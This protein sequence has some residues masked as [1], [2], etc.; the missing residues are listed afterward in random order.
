MKTLV[1]SILTLLLITPAVGANDQSLCIAHRGY[2]A[3]FFENSMEAIEQAVLFGADGVEFDIH[4]TKDGVPILSHDP[5]LEKVVLHNPKCPFERDISKLYFSEIESC[6]LRNGEKIPTLEEVL[7]YLA[8]EDVM[9]FVDL[10]DSPNGHFFEL[11]ERYHNLSH[12]RFIAF[13]QNY[14]RL[15]Q[16]RLPTAKTLLLSHIIPRGRQFDGAN[17]NYRSRHYLNGFRRRGQE[18]GVWT[19]NSH[20]R[21]R[22]VLNMEIDFITTD[23]VSRCLALRD[24][25]SETLDF[26]H[27]Y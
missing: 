25:N 26:V 22:I 20:E 4:H 6:R 14:L 18:T 16:S 27:S 8:A 21:L 13:E 11:F 24:E 12:I 17:V 2:S 19:V 15:I 5:T 1:F 3:K 7:N 23:Y 9:I 10:K